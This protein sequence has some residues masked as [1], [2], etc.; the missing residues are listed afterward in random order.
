MAALSTI[1]LVA[2]AAAA[3]GGAG[4]SVYAGEQAKAGQKRALGE[5]RTAQQQAAA[6]AAKAQRDA[7]MATNKANKKAPDVSAILASAQA[8]PAAPTMLSGGVDKADLKLG[9]TTLLGE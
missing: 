7:E 1:A 4:Y 6:K 5:Q 3:V 8:R 2:G 9:R